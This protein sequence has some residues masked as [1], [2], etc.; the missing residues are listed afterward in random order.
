MDR[1][2]MQRVPEFFAAPAGVVG[3]D[4]LWALARLLACVLLGAVWAA[5]PGCSATS[6]PVGELERPEPRVV[7]EREVV[8]ADH[9]EASAA[10]LEV[11]RMGGNAV[12]AAVATSFALSVVR[13]ESC[14]I[15]GGGFMVIALP[16]TAGRPA[17]ETAIDYRERAPAA[18]T[19]GT[20]AE[21]GAS[22]SR[23]GGLSVGVPGTVAGLLH[24]Q[25]RYGLLELRDVIAPAIRLA[26][27]GWRADRYTRERALWLASQQTGGE[28]PEDLAGWV[29]ERRAARDLDDPAVW[30]ELLRGGDVF[31][32]TTMRNGEQALA[33]ELIAERGRAGFYGGEVARALVSAVRDAGSTG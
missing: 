25:E 8:A 18:M 5:L 26:E 12:D 3:R 15:G 6:V 24:A 33:L 9:P 13:P 21:A 31:P 11:L 22:S 14:G 28:E 23:V 7:F 2:S 29:L 16:A 27:R 32:G 17:V 4:S 30:R 20:F 19:A 1:M 10:G